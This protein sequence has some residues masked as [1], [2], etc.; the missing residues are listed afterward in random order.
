MMHVDAWL[1]GAEVYD[2]ALQ[3]DDE[4]DDTQL[5]T[6]LRDLRCTPQLVVHGLVLVH[7]EELS[8]SESFSDQLVRR[9]VK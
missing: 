9:F 7:D 3:Q 8:F 5:N 2:F 1:E 6:L 4:E